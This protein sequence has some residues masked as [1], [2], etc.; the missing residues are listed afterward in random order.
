MKR[1]DKYR[2]TISIFGLSVF[3]IGIVLYFALNQT[4]NIKDTILLIAVTFFALLSAGL[5]SLV[6]E[7]RS[8]K[9]YHLI[10]AILSLLL[11]VVPRG[12]GG[13]QNCVVDGPCNSIFIYYFIILIFYSLQA[14]FGTSLFIK[15]L[16][17]D[18][19]M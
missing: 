1:T 11:I 19:K 4:Q 16:L 14:I 7:C 9:I 3:L 18:K 10:Y 5:V 15:T 12:V 17:F 13:Y 8:I 6:K 2:L